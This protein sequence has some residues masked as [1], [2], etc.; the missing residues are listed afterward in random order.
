MIIV[1]GGC[2]FIG[3]CIVSALNKE[4]HKD[5]LIVDEEL[6]EAKRKNFESLSCIGFVEKNEF[7]KKLNAD[8][9]DDIKYII[10]MGA[11]S[12][13]V[14]NDVDYMMTTNYSYSVKLF[15][16]C[17]DNCIRFIYASSAATYGDGS[18]GY[19]DKE[20]SN[21]E[22][23]NLYGKT[24]QLFDEFV[25][26]NEEDASFVGLKF[27]NVYGPNEYHKGRM[28]SMVFHSFNQIKENGSV[29]LF[30]SDVV[31]M[32]DGE[33][34]R[35]FIYVKDI[36]SVVLFFM[37]NKVNGIFN[38]GTGRARTFNDLIYA[39]FDS[40]RLQRNIVYIDMPEDLVGKYQNFT[41]AEMSKL[42]ETG[43]TKDFYSL[44]DGVDDYVLNYLN[45]NYSC[46]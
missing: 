27:F 44:E 1:T 17:K 19:S 12:S 14:E 45:K 29:K 15:N 23:L 22:P 3:S 31:G 30:K 18:H 43:Y 35:D 39:I 37:K 38:L 26:K 8:E 41:Q 11:C 5:I 16:Y 13:T 21:L 4:G 6:T 28:A 36:I 40:L 10:H 42:R 2:G 7:L 33:Q 46:M 20:I 9:Y 34:K 25:L 24:K 32:Q